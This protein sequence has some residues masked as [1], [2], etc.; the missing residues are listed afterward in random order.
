[1]IR[2]ASP[3]ARFDAASASV[4]V[5]L[6]PWQSIRIEMWQASMFGRYLSSQIGSIMADR[7]RGPRRGSRTCPSAARL[8]DRRGQLVELGGDQPGAEVDADPGRVD[9]AVDQPGVDDG[10]AAAAATASWM[11]RAMYLRLLSQRLAVLRLGSAYVLTRSKSR[12]SAADV[13]GQA[14]DRERLDRARRPRDP[15]PATAQKRVGTN[16]DGADQTQT[17]DDHAAFGAKHGRLVDLHRRGLAVGRDRAVDCG[18]LDRRTRRSA[19]RHRLRRPSDHRPAP[20]ELGLAR[21]ADRWPP[22]PP[23]PRSRAGSGPWPG[24]ARPAAAA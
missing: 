4:I 18:R 19:I 13:V 23:R 6:G 12:I 1:M 21:A 8:V 9:A 14:L 17:G 2:A 3:I 22:A 11:S 24:R 7:S 16:P 10:H 20:V 5:L 15:R